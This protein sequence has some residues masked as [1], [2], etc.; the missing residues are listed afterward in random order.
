MRSGELAAVLL[1]N[2]NCCLRYR[3]TVIDRDPSST[4]ALTLLDEEA[5]EVLG[6]YSLREAGPLYDRE[7]FSGEGAAAKR[8]PRIRHDT[9]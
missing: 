3:V 7:R 4:S 1:S 5:L 8:H 2:A 6:N 9:G